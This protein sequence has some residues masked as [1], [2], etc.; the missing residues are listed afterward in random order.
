M[1]DDSRSKLKDRLDL[2]E[3]VLKILVIGLLIVAAVILKDPLLER[4]GSAGVQEIEAFG[5]RVSF[6]ENQLQETI[7]KA[8]AADPKRWQ[9]ASVALP[10]IRTR[11]EV[12]GRVL[13]GSRGLWIDEGFPLSNLYERRILQTLGISVDM[14]KSAEDAWSLLQK[15]CYDV[16]ISEMRQADDA[17]AGLKF[18]IRLQQ[19]PMAPGLV[20]YILNFDPARGTPAYSNGITNSPTE[21]V[22]MVLDVL[23]RRLPNRC[24]AMLTKP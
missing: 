17:S 21:L 24:N 4:L 1:P 13:P 2:A 3:F 5:V 11:I 20:F 12:M 16:V 8:T 14:V 6:V 22:H 10:S 15:S 19:M 23:E 9:D 18:A 7:S